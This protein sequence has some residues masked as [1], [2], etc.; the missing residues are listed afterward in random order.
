VST[1]PSLSF[2]HLLSRVVDREEAAVRYIGL[3]VHREFCEVAIA[4]EGRV[5]S[6][7]R[8]R[9][10]RAELELFAQSLGADDEVAL[11]STGGAVAIARILEAHVARV[12]VVNTKKL[13]QISEAKTKTDRLDARRLAELLAAGYLAEVWCPDEPTRALRRLVA[14]RA[15]LVRQRSR[16]KNE[17]AAALQRNLL[18][19]PGVYDVAGERGRRFLEGVELPDD[20]RQTVEGCLRQIDFLDAEIA[21]VNRALAEAAVASEQMRRLMTV[22]GVNLQTAATFMACVGDIGRFRDSRKLVSYLGL[23]PRVR[24]SGEEPA[25]HGHISKQGAAEARHMLC[26]AAWVVVRYPSPLRAFGERI[27]ARR[28]AGIAT[29]AV[30]R[31][32]VVL[33]WQL[34]TKQR[35]YAFGRPSLTRKKLRQ[36]ELAA[37]AE[38]RK[39][40]PGIWAANK[41]QRE[42]ELEL[43]RQA[44]TAYRRLVTD[45]QPKGAGATQGRAFSKPS[46][47]K[48]RGRASVPDPAL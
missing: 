7:G 5:R 33:F 20:E 40:Q 26:E 32:L 4:E 43:A 44:E 3:D 29:V 8:I 15:Q 48:Q 9:T 24:Q 2:A 41:A 13:R 12:V 25:R 47:G 30:A 21:A 35:D 38:R 6:A 10:R 34:L 11:E 14:R 45:W 31:K 1:N 37:G 22:P 46:S 18:D 27:K 17:I 36:L 39:G 23:D 28:G 16:A 19:R 42:A